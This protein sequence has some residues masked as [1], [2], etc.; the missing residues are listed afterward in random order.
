MVNNLNKE[1][2]HALKK[3]AKDGFHLPVRQ[4]KVF[5]ENNNTFIKTGDKKISMSAA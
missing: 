3:L 2:I 5:H 4:T 1:Y